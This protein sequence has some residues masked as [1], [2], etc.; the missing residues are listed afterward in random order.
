MEAGS[1]AGGAYYL[2][3]AG[4]SLEPG[5]SLSVPVRFGTP[6]NKTISFAPVV[7]AGMGSPKVANQCKE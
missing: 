6:L 4:E 5:E 7:E 1:Q 2:F 3:N